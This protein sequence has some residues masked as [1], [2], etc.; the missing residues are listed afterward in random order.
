M[1]TLER[2]LSEHPLILLR[3]LGEWWELDL[4]GYDAQASAKAVAAALRQVDMAQELLYM[5]EE[6]AA[7]LRD[8]TAAGGKLP[9][10]TFSRLHGAVRQM[11]PGRLERE[12]P[13]L[14]PESAAEGLWYRGFLYRGF[15]ETPEGLIE[16]YYL[17]QELWEKLAAVMQ[18]PVVSSPAPTAATLQPVAGPEHHT[19]APDNAV[20]DLT[21]ILAVAQRYPLNEENIDKLQPYLL[22]PNPKRRMLLVALAWEMGLLRRNEQG[23]RPTRA[24]VEWLQKGREQQLQALAEAW[25]ASAWNELRH[26]AELVWE[27]Q[28]WHNDPLLA[29]AALLEHLPRQADWYAVEALL[30]HIKASDPDFQRPDGDY[31]G[32]YIRDAASNSYLQ[33]FENWDK[34][35]GRL[36]RFLILGPLHWLGLVEHDGVNTF[37]PTARLLTWLERQPIR[38]R[39]EGRVP[40]IVQPDGM[41]LASRHTSRYDRFQLSRVAEAQPVDPLKPYIY[42]LTPR[43][44][45]LAQE[46]GIESARVLEFLQRASD[47]P[48]PAGLRRAVER[49]ASNGVEGRLRTAVILQVQ[50]G[51][52]LDTLRQN[53]KTSSYLG[54]TLGELAVAVRPGEWLRLQ[55]AAAQL[56]L[57]LDIDLGDPTV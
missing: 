41:I 39:D 20:D 47:R 14:D 17:P 49:W 56:G 2:A 8:L 42:R 18:P 55:Q 40:L 13:W 21:T 32:W 46:Q 48:L 29:R 50:D 15:D 53:P 43:S 52:I 34:V 35:E 5:P 11:G 51:R 3:V 16:F 26:T 33:G 9:V 19:S 22:E 10:A 1:V 45:Q 25:S 30:A 31:T 36:L 6:E 7:A 4:T 23:I 44:L 38:A 37:R 12:E 24:A 54:E 27:G 57:L 28:S